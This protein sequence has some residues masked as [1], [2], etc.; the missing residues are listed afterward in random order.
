MLTSLSIQCVLALSFAYLAGCVIIYY[1]IPRKG[2]PLAGRPSVL[3][4]LVFV[5]TLIVRLIPALA[6]PRGAL[7]DIES[8]QRVAET[9]LNG[10]AV[11]S[12]PV[13]AG[14]H[15]YLP[16]QVYLIGGAM[17]LARVSGIVFASCRSPTDT[18]ALMA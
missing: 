13:V 2:F 6:L 7:Y 9:F 12:S 16:F 18:A 10:E 14:R 4:L 3:V 15:P 8:F 1:L 17:Q 5:T 11:Y